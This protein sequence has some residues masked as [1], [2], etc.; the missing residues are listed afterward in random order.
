M[1]RSVADGVA[2][3]I[4]CSS[5]AFAVILFVDVAGVMA[6]SEAGGGLLQEIAVRL[7]SLLGV[8][9]GAP[10]MLPALGRLKSRPR[11]RAERY[12]G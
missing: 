2:M 12:G 8:A 9:M 3:W 1:L 4:G 10:I 7:V 11:P 6:L 5:A